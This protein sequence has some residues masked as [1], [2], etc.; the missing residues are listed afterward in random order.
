MGLVVCTNI[1]AT[2]AALW[3]VGTVRFLPIA[4]GMTFFHRF[5]PSLV[6]A[7]AVLV[8]VLNVMLGTS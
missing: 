4:T 6:M 7:W 3:S 5:L 1:T 8:A 2:A